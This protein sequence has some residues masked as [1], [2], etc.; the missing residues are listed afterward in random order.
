MEIHSCEIRVFRILH[1]TFI[2]KLERFSSDRILI[3]ITA[4]FF[5]LVMF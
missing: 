1:R 4:D 3:F 5:E 2:D